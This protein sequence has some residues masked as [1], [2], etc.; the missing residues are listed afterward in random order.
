MGEGGNGKGER[1]RERESLPA[2]CEVN[3][4]ISFKTQ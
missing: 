2:I 3:V 1:E 4:P